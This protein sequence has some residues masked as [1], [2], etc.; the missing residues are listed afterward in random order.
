[1]EKELLNFS[2]LME[3]TGLSRS[4]INRMRK[5]GMPVH[6]GVGTRKY[7]LGEVNAFRA[8]RSARS[9]VVLIVGNT[10][11]NDNIV[12][13]F[14]VG[15]MG[16]MRKSNTQNAL[17]LISKAEDPAPGHE[18]EDFYDDEGILHYTGKG[19]VGDQKYTHENRILGESATTGITVHLFMRHG[20]DA[21]VYRGVVTLAGEVYQKSEYDK[22]N[23]LR[24]VYKFPLQF[25]SAEALM[26]SKEKTDEVQR[27]LTKRAEEMDLR[28]LFD[29]NE[30][31]VDQIDANKKLGRT[32]TT[33][34]VTKTNRDPKVATYVIAR[35]NGVCQF[36]GAK[37]D[38]DDDFKPARLVCHHE[39]PLHKDEGRDDKFHAV[40]LCD[41][42]HA[43]RHSSDISNVALERFISRVKASIIESENRVR[44]ELQ[45]ED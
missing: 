13:Y 35:A 27:V 31:I 32:K 38:I 4:T 28:S 30:R 39:P 25:R 2:E 12:K 10:Y 26:A 1:M 19:K 7:D 16:G 44:R 33:T 34:R 23:R 3:A 9:G 15:N 36:C 14:R 17:I 21:Y 11:T 6:E 40:A 22:N 5:E 29:A 20:T 37:V 24:M 41:N 43:R 18:Y 8:E 42:C 45:I